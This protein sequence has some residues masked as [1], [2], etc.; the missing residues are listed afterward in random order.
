MV[1]AMKKIKGGNRNS[2][3]VF[4]T[5]AR[6]GCS[7]EVFKDWY[8]NESSHTAS[9]KALRWEPPGYEDKGQCG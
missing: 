9:A 5:A 7:E 6:G 1:S 3:E 8:L 4:Y 2:R